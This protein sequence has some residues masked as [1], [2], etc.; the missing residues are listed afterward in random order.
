MAAGA[1]VSLINRAN[2]VLGKVE[3]DAE[4]FATFPAGLA[5]ATGATAPAV[6]LVEDGDRDA[7]FQPLDGP[8]FD[9]SDRGVA[10][11]PPAPPIDA[12]LTTDRGA[13][14]A[15]ETIYATVLTRD[16][17][18]AALPDLPVTVV[19][20][21]PDG[22]E[23]RRKL[24]EKSVLGGHILALPLAADV[25]RGTWRLEIFADVPHLPWR[26]RARWWKTSCLSALTLI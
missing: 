20:F 3:T 23:Y 25:P 19:L 4:G 14:R 15:G 26:A 10:G 16:A 9:L 8:A 7:V 17:R 6:I 24:A 1:S 2:G 18:A 21:R 13:Y 22:V 11:N 5:R 12:F